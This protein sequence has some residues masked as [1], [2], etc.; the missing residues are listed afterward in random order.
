MITGNGGAGVAVE[1]TGGAPFA[2][3]H[4]ITRNSI[5]GNT[6]I[7][8]DLG[9]SGVTANDAGDAD[10]GGNHL[11]NYPVLTTV[12]ISLAGDLVIQYDVPGSTT[13]P[14][15]STYPLTLEFFEADS[16][17]SG[18]GMTFLGSG[19]FTTTD[20]T[21]GSVVVNLGS[22]AML[23]MGNGDPIVVTATDSEGAGNT[24]EFSAVV[25]VGTG[26]QPTAVEVSSFTAQ[27]T[28]EGAVEVRWET[29]SEI[30]LLGFN[31]WR[32]QGADGSLTQVNPELIPAQ[33]IG[34]PTGTSYQLVDRAV[35]LGETYDY[36]LEV[37]R[38]DVSRELVGPVRVTVSQGAP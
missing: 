11:Q 33:V 16:A 34:S 7:G 10:D 1:S 13:G 27:V 28:V 9:A 3:M 25:T 32:S 5:S 31:V 26:T 17:V 21:N 4:R 12:Q 19:T 30:T 23:G 35:V 24:S 20:F 14:P 36:Y 29:V 22:A 18:Q 8:I 37:I 2:R 38:L 6:G 15:A